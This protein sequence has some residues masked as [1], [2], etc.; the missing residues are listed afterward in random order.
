MKNTEYIITEFKQFWSPQRA[1]VAENIFSRFMA[2]ENIGLLSDD[3]GVTKICVENAIR[4]QVLL[5]RRNKKAIDLER[6]RQQQKLQ[7]YENL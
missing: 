1:S 7:Q 3:Y 5:L 2:G 6:E 4:F